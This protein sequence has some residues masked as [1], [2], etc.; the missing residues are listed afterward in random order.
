[1]VFGWVGDLGVLVD[2]T[3]IWIGKEIHWSWIV[4]WAGDLVRLEDFVGFR[5]LV[6]LDCGYYCFADLARPG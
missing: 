2:K 4:G 6:G 5:Y 3:G 1:M